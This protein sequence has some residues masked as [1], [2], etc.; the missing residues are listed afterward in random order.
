MLGFIPGY[1]K[2]YVAS[3]D[4]YIW[5]KKKS[6]YRKLKGRPTSKGY[7]LVSLKENGVF[8][9]KQVHRLIAKT[10]IGEVEGKIVNHLNEVT[11]DNSL[12]NL[13]ITDHSNNSR[14]SSRK[15][16]NMIV[17]DSEIN[18]IRNGAAT[19]KGISEKYDIPKANIYQRLT[20]KM[21]K[22]T[23]GLRSSKQDDGIFEP[24]FKGSPY[25]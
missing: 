21:K 15:P 11:S 13:E 9:N 14:M 20:Y 19:V 12:I 1:N 16:K 2:R 23:P 8:K 17:P 18:N 5:S 6:G 4:G 24:N 7:L 3:S 10:F 25:L 22:Y